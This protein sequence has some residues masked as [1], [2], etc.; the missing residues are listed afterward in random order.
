MFQI[1]TTILLVT[2]SIITLIQILFS[3]NRIIKKL[4]ALIVL[5]C[6]ISWF[7][8][9]TPKNLCHEPNQQFQSN[10]PRKYRLLARKLSSTGLILVGEINMGQSGPEVRFLRCDHSLLGGF[11]IGPAK[12]SIIKRHKEL[13]PNHPL[14]NAELELR[15]A[16]EA[17]SI[18]PT[19]ILQDAIRL[20]ERPSQTLYQKPSALILG[21]GVGISA[22]SL[23]RHGA[24]VTVAEIDPIVYEYA[25]KFFALPTPNGGIFLEDARYY[26][27]RAV[28]GSLGLFDYI[29]HDVFTGGTVPSSL[30]T[31]ECWKGIR[32]KL[33]DD[34]ILAVNFAGEPQTETW[35]LVL[36]TLFHV[37]PFCRAFN[38]KVPQETLDYNFQNIVIFCS[39]TSLPRF[40]K[41]TRN[42]VFGSRHRFE[43]LNTFETLEFN[44]TQHHIYRNP[45]SAF[46]L[47]DRYKDR[48]EKAQ[49]ESAF[50][51]WKIMRQVL[52]DEVWHTYY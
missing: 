15:A 17:E 45:N 32:N 42:D 51:H 41:P 25:Q 30:F 37:F 16:K 26:L 35:T 7:I 13:Y 29:I 22:H 46:I 39:P 50:R 40:R 4:N 6:L 20:V 36:T 11:W 43:I 14:N 2:S 47:F 1:T 8:F 23:M 52:P 48:L 27:Q 38:E 5:T 9:P 33:K 44:L 10:Q 12:R 24:L 31:V 3:N 28:N 49:M 34:G 21:L 19:F 18:Y